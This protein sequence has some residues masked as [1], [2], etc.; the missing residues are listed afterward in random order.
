MTVLVL[1]QNLI[2]QEE[3]RPIVWISAL[4]NN[5]NNMARDVTIPDTFADS[6][7]DATSHQARSAANIAAKSKND[8]YADLTAT[9][10]FMPI[11]FETAGSWNQQAIDAIEDIGRR[12]SELQ[13]SIRTQLVILV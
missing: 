6:H 2:K 8:K 1:N 9:H 7:I 12:I 4:A 13:P 3:T 5:N 11:A 10:I